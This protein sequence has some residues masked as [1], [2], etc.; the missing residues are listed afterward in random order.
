[1]KKILLVEDYYPDVRLVMRA[2]KKAD[3]D[4][5]ISH[6]MDGVEAMH[7]LRKQGRHTDA[8]TPDYILLDLNMP[9]KDGR[10]VLSELRSDEEIGHIPVIVMTTSNQGHDVREAY[11]LGA[12]AYLTKPPSYEDFQRVVEDIDNFWNRS[13]LLPRV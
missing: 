6:V 7:F 9:R 10:A 1:M 12:N 3:A 11:R 5:S 8:E 13:A 4:V 2:F